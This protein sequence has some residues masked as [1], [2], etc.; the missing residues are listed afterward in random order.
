[1]VVAALSLAS[2][3]VDVSLDG[4]RLRSSKSACKVLTPLEKERAEKN[5]VLINHLLSLE[6]VEPMSVELMSLKG[7][8]PWTGSPE[9]P[10]PDRFSPIIIKVTGG[11]IPGSGF[12]WTGQFVASNPGT[13]ILRGVSL[14]QLVELTQVSEVKKIRIS[15]KA[16]IMQSSDE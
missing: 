9:E 4:P 3:F 15:E 14:H 11:F 1:M 13:Y 12:P 5:I 2:F 16:Y 8:C 7:R 10:L 6:K